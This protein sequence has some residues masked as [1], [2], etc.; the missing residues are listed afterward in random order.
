MK[1]YQILLFH[2]ATKFGIVGFMES[3]EDEMKEFRKE[4]IKFTT[5]C[6][7]AIETGKNKLVIN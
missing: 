4:F 5:I 1:S 3:L 6:P 2:S 7:A